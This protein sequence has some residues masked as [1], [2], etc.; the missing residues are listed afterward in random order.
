M[1]TATRTIHRTGCCKR[2]VPMAW[3]QQLRRRSYQG[4]NSPVAYGTRPATVQA[5]GCSDLGRAV[6]TNALQFE[7]VEHLPALSAR[8][9]VSHGWGCFAPWTSKPLATRQP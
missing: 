4:R 1:T 3:A 6:R 2:F 5:L 9:K 7:D 8:P